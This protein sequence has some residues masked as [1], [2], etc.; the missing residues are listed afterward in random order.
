MVPPAFLILA[1]L[2]SIFFGIAAPTEAAGVG[3]LAAMILAA[4]YT[5]ALIGKSSKRL[6]S[7]Q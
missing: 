3:A 4:S 7:K 5:A 2:G 6:R 1:V